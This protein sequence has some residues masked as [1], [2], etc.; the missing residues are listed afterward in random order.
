VIA[1]T[2]FWGMAGSWRALFIALQL[3]WPL[4]NLEP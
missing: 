4:L 3:A 1:T 2:V